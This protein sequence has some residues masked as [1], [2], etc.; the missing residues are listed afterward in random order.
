[1]LVSQ[2]VKDL[3]ISFSL[4]YTDAGENELGGVPGEW[5]L[6]RLS[7]DQS[8]ASELLSVRRHPLRRRALD[9]GPEVG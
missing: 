4:G 7:A 5:P 9:A 1:V 3:T 6:Y 2:T 8:M